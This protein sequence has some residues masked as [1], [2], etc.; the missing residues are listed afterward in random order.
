VLE[1]DRGERGVHDQRAGGLAVAQETAKDVPVALAR[2]EDA[3]GGLGEPGCYRRLGL[4]CRE[5]T[6]EDAGIGGDPQE[7]PE[8][9]PGEADEVGPRERRLEPRPGFSRAA[10]LA[11]DRRRAAG[12]RRPGSPVQRAL[13]LLD[14]P[15]DIVEGKPLMS[16]SAAC[17]QW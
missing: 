15:G 16:F 7:G 9:E 14:Q 6:L 2:F 8:R 1:R 17:W 13:D 12:S 10:P 3:G 11:D 4:R 5:R